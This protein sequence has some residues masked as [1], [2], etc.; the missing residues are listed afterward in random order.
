MKNDEVFNFDEHKKNAI[1]IYKPLFPLYERYSESIRSLLATCIKE[2]SL[3]IHSIEARAK[4][5]DSFSIKSITPSE[6]NPEQP[7]YPNPIKNIT[8]L[9]GI[10]VI[11]FFLDTISKIEKIIEEQFLLV[12]KKDKSLELIQ[13]DKF[14][15]Q[16]F[17]YLVRLNSARCS[18]PEYKEFKDLIA[19]IQVRTILQHSW[20]EIEHDIEYKSDS[21]MPSLIRRRFASLA[22]LI[23]IADR[24]FEAIHIEDEKINNVDKKNIKNGYLER[25]SISGKS[26]KAYLDE[27]MGSDGRL[28]FFS[29]EFEA[30]SLIKIGF[31]NIRQIDDCTKEYDGNIL[32]NNVWSYRQGQLSRFELMVLAGMGEEYI[33][34]HR[35]NIYKW[36]IDS[37]KRYLDKMISSK[38]KIGEY[39]I[40]E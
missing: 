2:K 3:K 39:R 11:T 4:S 15:Y 17:H 7:K 16:S 18:L 13:N 9:S 10:R 21:T 24:E 25:V 6:E 1:E 27:R 29:Y 33:A 5:I 20:A 37:R 40:T 19:E 31:K 30:E 8:D 28:S 26:L 23:E 34:R 14:G 35:W 38:I 22:S 36:F 32:S 12:E